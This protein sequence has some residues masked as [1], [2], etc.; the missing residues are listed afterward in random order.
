MGGCLHDD[1]YYSL[2]CLRKR[3]GQKR[4][5]FVWAVSWHRVATVVLTMREFRQ[6]RD[7]TTQLTQSAVAYALYSYPSDLASNNHHHADIHP[8]S[9]WNN[10]T[11]RNNA[12]PPPLTLAHLAFCFFCSQVLPDRSHQA[13]PSLFCFAWPQPFSSLSYW[14][15]VMLLLRLRPFL[16]CW[17]RQRCP[18]RRQRW[19]QQQ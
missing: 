9:G 7:V 5:Q 4:A 3:T 15:R 12:P 11:H 1:G 19:R 13:T 14:L 18:F 10:T 6:P 8:T 2:D 17:C 16:Y